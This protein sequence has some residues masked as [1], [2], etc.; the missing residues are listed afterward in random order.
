MSDR[1]DS[2]SRPSAS[3]GG[4]YL[5]LSLVF[6]VATGKRRTLQVFQSGLDRVT[7]AR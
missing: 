6:A 1:R 2:N 5:K 3:K 4:G 7:L